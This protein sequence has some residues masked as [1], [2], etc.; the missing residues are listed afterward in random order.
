MTNL[1]VRLYPDGDHWVMTDK[2]KEVGQ[3]IRKFVDGKDF[4]KESVYRAGTR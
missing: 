4:L 1:S 2:Y 3:D